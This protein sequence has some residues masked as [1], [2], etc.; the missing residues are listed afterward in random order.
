[1][2][3]WLPKSLADQLEPKTLLPLGGRFEFEWVDDFFRTEY[4]Y[5]IKH[6]GRFTPNQCKAGFSSLKLN[7][8]AVCLN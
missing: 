2:Q 5:T 7:Q 1:M 6:T 4:R 8:N 3:L